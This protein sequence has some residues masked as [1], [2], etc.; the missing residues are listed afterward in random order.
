MQMSARTRC[1]DCGKRRKIWKTITIVFPAHGWPRPMSG[2]VK[3]HVC[4]ECYDERR[5]SEMGRLAQN[6]LSTFRRDYIN[7][8]DARELARL[9]TLDPRRSKP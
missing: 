3:R 5:V 1:G 2:K 6:I 8:D 7:C 4:A 9:V